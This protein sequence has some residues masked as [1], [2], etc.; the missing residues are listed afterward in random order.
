MCLPDTSG[1]DT[2]FRKSGKELKSL[3]T[4]FFYL[5]YFPMSNE[6]YKDL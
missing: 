5:N 4:F 2:V 1:I 6:N 3:L